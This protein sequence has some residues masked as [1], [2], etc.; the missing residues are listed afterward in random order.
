MNILDWIVIAGLVIAFITGARVGIVYQLG[1][2]IGLFIGFEV[3]AR[4]SA[5]A[6]DT[7]GSLG[8]SQWFLFSIIIVAISIIMGLT[9][10]LL[11]KA[12]NFIKWLPFLKTANRLLGGIVSTL[13]FSIF[14]SVILMVLSRL[15]ISSVLTQ[16]IAESTIVGVFIWIGEYIAL[17]IPSLVL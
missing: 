17:I 12:F 7:I 10:T 5:W 9:A 1:S 2:L 16:S 14:A 15:T 13:I 11:N 6:S 8:L 4:Y 3:A